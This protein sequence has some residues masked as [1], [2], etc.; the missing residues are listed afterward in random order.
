MVAYELQKVENGTYYYNYYPD[1]DKSAPG[2]IT[3]DA[4]DNRGI[5]KISDEDVKNIYAGRVWREFALG[6][7]PLG[8]PSGELIMF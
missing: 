6:H 5:V 2:C 4:E 8:Q 1:G 7:T 3:M